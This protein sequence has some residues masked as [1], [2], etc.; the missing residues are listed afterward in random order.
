MTADRKKPGVGFWATVAVVVVLVAY[1]LSWGP[2][3]LIECRLNRP[4]AWCMM[5]SAYR[6][7]ALLCSRSDW[8]TCAAFWYADLCGWQRPR[9]ASGFYLPPGFEPESAAMD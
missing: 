6:P 9:I 1:P 3:H 4:W 5:H 7:L 2:A 8:A